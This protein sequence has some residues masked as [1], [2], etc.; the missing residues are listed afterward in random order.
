MAFAMALILWDQ[1]LGGVLEAVQPKMTISSK[2]TMNI[3]NMHRIRQTDPRFGSI[4]LKLDNGENYSVLTFF[5]GYGASTSPD[6]FTGN[7][8]SEF[9]LAE[10]VFAMMLPMNVKISDYEEIWGKICSRLLLD[11]DSIPDKMKIAYDLV[12]NSALLENPKE[13]GKFLDKYIDQKLGLSPQDIAEA[14]GYEV[15]TLHYIIQDKKEHIEEL[16]IN[17]AGQAACIDQQAIA[18]AEAKEKEIRQY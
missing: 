16:R 1:K 12:K 7:Y 10:R 9:G 17:P 8:G 14:R 15:K 5:T 3:Y 2:I 18:D 11:E 13:L 4:R 6:G